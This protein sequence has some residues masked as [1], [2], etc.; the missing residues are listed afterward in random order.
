MTI[1]NP[2][3]TRAPFDQEKVRSKAVLSI[4]WTRG[5]ATAITGQGA[6]VTRAGNALV[7]SQNGVLTPIGT[8]RPRLLH[9]VEAAS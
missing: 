6:T 7:T 8:N 9:F 4:D 2:S 1:T 3:P 5:V